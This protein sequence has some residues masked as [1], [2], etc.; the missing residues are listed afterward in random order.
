MRYI[1]GGGFR[2]FLTSHPDPWGND[3][4]FVDEHSAEGLKPPACCC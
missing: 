4:F 2:E 3:P 1:V